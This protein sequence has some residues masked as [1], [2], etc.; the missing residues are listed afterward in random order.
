MIWESQ[1]NN[2]KILLSELVCE[3][4]KIAVFILQV[5]ENYIIIKIV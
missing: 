3:T 5:L 4:G 2:G 1:F